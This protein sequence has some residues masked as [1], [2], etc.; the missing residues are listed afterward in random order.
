[1]ASIR[2]LSGHGRYTDPWH[3][4]AE[5]SSAIRD[6]LR[7]AG[8]RVEVR[9]DD[10]SC[11]S[12]LDDLDL[13]IVNLGGNVEVALEYDGKWAA[14][15]HDFGQWIRDGGR[16][17]A[18]HT[19]ANC[20]PDWSD[21]PGL[22]GG[23]WVRGTSWHPQRCIATFEKVPGAEGHSVWQGLDV[24]TAYD[25]RYSD[26]DVHEDSVPLIHHELSEQWQVMGWAHGSNVVYDAMGHDRRSY[27]SETR[28]RYLLNEVEWLLG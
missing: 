5:S 16:V 8:Y 7:G 1:M 6:I 2:I 22:L 25:E 17:L 19:A 23:Q 10:P 20:F 12:G 14:A 11:L 24:V 26:L 18:V 21:W 3:P 9:D 27:M 15:Q 4:F 28:R 13:V